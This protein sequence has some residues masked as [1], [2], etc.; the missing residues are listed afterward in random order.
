MG[1]EEGVGEGEG[2]EQGEGEAEITWLIIILA[3]PLA[4]SLTPHCLH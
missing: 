1:Q 4:L 3:N 2:V